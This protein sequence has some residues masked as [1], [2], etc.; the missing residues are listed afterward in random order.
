[1]QIPDIPL[2]EH[3][4][5]AGRSW[6]LRESRLRGF[7]RG[8]LV[9]SAGDRPR[10]LFVLVEGR[11]RVFRRDGKGQE[12]TLKLLSAGS[13]FGEL[14]L[15]GDIPRSA[16]VVATTDCRALCVPKDVFLEYLKSDPEAA[17]AMIRRLIAY[18]VD[19]TENV[20]G[21]AL[22]TVYERLRRVLLEHAEEI[23]GE[24]RL[25][26]FSHRDLAAMIGA[27]REMVTR[28]L[29]DLRTGGYVQGRPRSIVLQKALPEAW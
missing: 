26:G 1:M 6:L 14:A 23:D 5:E 28:L 19:L 2:F 16:D 7:R 9:L 27:S 18:I 22:D 8:E 29:K 25:D 4:D 13:C 11:V 15:L 17:L 21:L 24:L 10:H 3:M 12:L 20:Q